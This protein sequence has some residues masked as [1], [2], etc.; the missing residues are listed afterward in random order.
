MSPIPAAAPNGLYLYWNAIALDINL[1]KVTIKEPPGIFSKKLTKLWANPSA[2]A[3]APLWEAFCCLGVYEKV[4]FNVSSV[5]FLSTS[6]GI[7]LLLAKTSNMSTPTR[8]ICLCTLAAK[9]ALRKYTSCAMLSVLAARATLDR[10]P[11]LLSCNALNNWLLRLGLFLSNW[12]TV[13]AVKPALP[14]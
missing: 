2:M 7:C 10:S 8:F 4:A 5:A 3:S 6:T 12:S 11:L 9:I 14:K 13:S 1:G